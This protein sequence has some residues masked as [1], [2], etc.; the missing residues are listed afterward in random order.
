MDWLLVISVIWVF[1]GASNPVPNTTVV[2][3]QN[4]Q[5]CKAAAQAIKADFAVEEARGVYTYAHLICVQRK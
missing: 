3:F 5:L 4:E 1:G 2:E